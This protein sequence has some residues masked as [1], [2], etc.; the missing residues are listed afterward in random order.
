[1]AEMLP[2]MDPSE[3]SIFLRTDETSASGI[4]GLLSMN[5]TEEGGGGFFSATARSNDKVQHGNIYV[6][7]MDCNDE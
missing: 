7:I 2:K 6:Y 5:E 3:F 4:R 1:M